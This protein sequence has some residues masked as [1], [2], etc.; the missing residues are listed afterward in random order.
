MST[1][2]QFKIWLDRAGTVFM[3]P[4][5]LVEADSFEPG[6]IC[7]SDDIRHVRDRNEWKD[8]KRCLLWFDGKRVRAIEG[9]GKMKKDDDLSWLVWDRFGKLWRV[10]SWWDKKHQ[11]MR[12][13][14]LVDRDP[15][16]SKMLSR[17]AYLIS[18]DE[19]KKARD[20]EPED[21]TEASP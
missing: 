10:T 5:N 12:E 16:H 7:V 2:E 17:Y 6:F 3:N 1:Y 21:W 4:N 13:E 19:P 18:G 20:I 15:L 11:K 9:I 8:G 14:F